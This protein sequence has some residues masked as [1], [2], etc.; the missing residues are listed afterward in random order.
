MSSKP[1]GAYGAAASPSPSSHLMKMKFMQRGQEGQIKKQVNDGSGIDKTT[2]E[3]TKSSGNSVYAKQ[4]VFDFY[5]NFQS[6]NLIYS[7]C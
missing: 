4:R 7:C 6:Q 2:D 3:W 1:N 5:T